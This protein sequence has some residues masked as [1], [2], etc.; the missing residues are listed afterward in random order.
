MDAI[1]DAT[2]EDA[3]AMPNIIYTFHKWME[4]TGKST[5]TS[6]TYAR[7]MI[8]LF[9]EDG[10]SPA[11]MAT[12]E[13]FTETKASFR[14]KSCNGQRSASV[15]QFMD[16]WS[17]HGDKPF[18]DCKG[19]KMY[20]LKSGRPRKDKAAGIAALVANEGVEE[21]KLR[22]E[23]E[24]PAT[25]WSVVMR[26]RQSGDMIA[27]VSPGGTAYYSRETVDKRLGRKRGSEPP[28]L[29][30]PPA[31]ASKPSK[32]ASKKEEAARPAGAS[33]ADEKAASKKPP[34]A[35]QATAEVKK[36]IKEEAKKEEE[37]KEDLKEEVKKEEPGEAAAAVKEEESEAAKDG[38][39]VAELKS[40]EKEENGLKKEEKE[41]SKD[42]VLAAM[43]ALMEDESEQKSKKSK[44]HREKD[45]L[46]GLLNDA[47]DTPPS[48]LTTPAVESDTEYPE[49][50]VSACPEKI[51]VKES[52]SHKA[53]GTYYRMERASRGK[54]C[55]SKSGE[56]PM[57]LFWNKKWRIGNEFGST[58]N[59]AMNK[60]AGTL[61]PCEPYPH[62]W[63]V[64]DRKD[65]KEKKEKGDGKAKEYVKQ[66][67]MRIIDSQSMSLCIES[68]LPEMMVPE[69]DYQ[70]A[71]KVKRRTVA[72]A[73]SEASAEQAK[74]E[75]VPSSAEKPAKEPV[76]V[77]N[78]TAPSQEGPGEDSEEEKDQV[79]SSQ[80]DSNSS[81]SSSDDSG[82]SD[83]EDEGGKEASKEVKAPAAPKPVASLHASEQKA[84]EFEA[85]LRVEL[86][87]MNAEERLQRMQKVKEVLTNK[88]NSTRVTGMGPEKIH[89]M[90]SQLEKDF[91]ITARPKPPSAPP[92]AHLL[93]QQQAAGAAPGGTAEDHRSLADL[94]AESQPMTP[95]GGEPPATNGADWWRR[96]RP[97]RSALR[98]PNMPR[99]TR[100]RITYTDWLVNRVEV[101]SFRQCGEQLWF[102]APGSY[103]ACDAC[104]KE[105]S[106]AM[107]CLQ[108]A[109]NHSQF[110]QNRFLCSECTGMM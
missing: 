29:S 105:V 83:S 11:G 80:S 55:Y 48:D 95:E 17:S 74:G 110:A 82:A 22:A 75:A 24:L 23:L 108:G 88:A 96:Q 67:T 93:K 100:R 28:A 92:P 63:K 19:D 5:N 20:Q 10:K 70:R 64:L 35:A 9:E 69:E 87:K 104:E 98:K 14:N 107:G 90:L 43:T 32:A 26:T 99:N 89:A 40:E 59:F 25:G 39:A 86:S 42:D 57:Y 6:R 97:K 36:E 41:D 85:R 65:R 61:T 44:R 27:A 58:K 18:E 34:A 60:D 38:G 13:Y 56:R 81:S 1:P 4:G 77:A 106:Q 46:A 33:A 103:V 94:A 71:K 3:T 66:M 76:A 52:G 50:D 45:P 51:H 37:K 2:E 101:S 8:N 78:G 49:T 30:L 68:D 109:P 53:D 21:R 79:D 73:P 15:R 54:P 16:F 102:I 7:T 91:A 72:L 12:M 84:Q 47:Q 62:V 31:E